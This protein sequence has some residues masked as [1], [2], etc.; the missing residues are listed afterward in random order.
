MTQKNGT[1]EFLRDVETQSS[2][3]WI[4]EIRKSVKF[5]NH[6]NKFF[7]S[8]PIIIKILDSLGYKRGKV[9]IDGV[10]VLVSE[11]TDDEKNRAQKNLERQSKKAGIEAPSIEKIEAPSE[12][13]IEKTEPEVTIE[14]EVE[15]SDPEAEDKKERIKKKKSKASSMLKKEIE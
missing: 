3:V 11:M 7:T 4:K 12:D 14:I 10:A 6:S 15:K 9:K 2:S 1:I 8:D 5:D 13:S